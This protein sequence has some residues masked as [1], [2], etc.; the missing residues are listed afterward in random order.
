MDRMTRWFV[1]ACG[2]LL[3]AAPVF[4]ATQNAVVYGTVYDSAGNPMAGVTVTLENPALGFSRASTTGSDGSYNFAEVPPAEGYKLTAAKSGKKLDIRSGITVNVGDERVILPPLK[5]QAA[6]ATAPVVERKSE[7][8]AVR[9]ETVSTT[10]SGVITGDQLRSLPS[11]LNRN[12]LSL[13]T[14][15]PNTHDVEGGS[16]LT[17]ASFSI[18]GTRPATNDF[19]LDGSDNVASSSNQAVPFQVN[20]A[21]QEFRVTSSTASAEYGRNQGGVVNVV[22]RRGGNSFHGSAF[23]YFNNDSL[24]ANN[25]LSVYN[26]TTFDKARAYAGPTAATCASSGIFPLTYNDYVNTACFNGFFT[27]TLAT[28]NTLF[29]PAT[30][31][32]TN[33]KFKQPFSSKQFGINMGG[34]LMKDKWFAFGSYEATLIDNP[35]QIFERVPSNFDRTFDPLGSGYTFTSGLGALDPNYLIAAD[36]MALFPT[37]NV[38]GVPDALEFF[39]GQAP[40]HTTVHNLLLRSDHIHS[41]KTSFTLRYAAQWLNQLHD[42]SLPKQAAYPGNGAIRD[43]FNQ[44]LS[45]S[46]ARTFSPTLINEVRV[47]YSRFNVKEKAQDAGFDATTIG[48]P[49][50]NLPNAAMPTML[51]NGL[52]TQYSGAFPGTNGAFAIWGNGSPM[53]PTLDYFFPMARLGAPLNTPSE[54]RDTTWFAADSVS[55]SRG[56]HAVRFGAEFR[57]LD[58]Q[59]NNGAFSRGFI[60]SSN[61]G[62]F[63]SDSES[64]NQGINDAFR[65]PAFDFSQ[66]QT[67]PY[68]GNFHSYGFAGFIQDTWRFHPRWTLNVGVRYEY[69]S[70]PE[71]ADDRVF[72]F[73]PTANGLVQ[74]G[75]STTIDPFGNGC[76][77]TPPPIQSVPLTSRGPGGFGIVPGTWTCNA[78]GSGKIVKS[79]TNNFAPRVGL[80]WDMFGTGKTVLR[81]GAGWFY[82]HLPVSD[83]SQLL[84]NR[85]TSDVTNPNAFQGRLAFDVIGT[86]CTT[87]LSCGVGSSIINP[88]VQ[89]ATTL[90]GVNPNTFYSAAAQPF[91]MYARDVAHSSTPFTRQMSASV[92]QQITN[93]LAVEVGYIGTSG[94][95]LPVVYNSNYQQEFT[96]FDPTVLGFVPNPTAGSNVL[97][98]VF[99]MTNRGDSTYHSL[100]ARARIAEFHGLR[101]NV[102]YNWSKA[103]DNASTGFFPTVPSTLN[104]FG[105]AYQRGLTA[106]AAILCLLG[107][108][109][110]ACAVNPLVFPGIDFSTGAVTTTG[111]NPVMTSRYL[112]AQ[113]PFNF[114]IDD[115][116]RSD[117]D[118]KNRFVVDYTWDVPSLQKKWGWSKWLDYWQ[119]SG[120]FV[121]QSGQPFTV[122]SGPILGEVNQRA[123][124]LGPVAQNNS[125]PNAA[126]SSTNLGF[127]LVDCI[128]TVAPSPFIISPLQPTVGSACT[129]NSR[130]NQFT[131]P[132]LINFNMAIQKGF[133]VGGENRLLSV[134]AE[135]YNLANRANFYNPIST[136]STDGVNLNPD[137]GRIKS[138]HDPRQIQLAVRYTW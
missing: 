110:G 22:T 108:V 68:V 115:R 89:A 56:K 7:A 59:V 106:N 34:A 84:Y 1:L 23:G 41:D 88:A 82:D 105:I 120:V 52:D 66:T 54:R 79:D 81:F 30:I 21:I 26:G 47:G 16:E 96:L 20:D 10:M 87:N 43:A 55:W 102:T 133:P 24:N 136:L 44:N 128:A 80:A 99:T 51:L 12:F 109:P 129:G 49:G 74:Q 2:L 62:A 46:Y 72:N 67:S 11:T 107:T 25:P 37:A 118:S 17:G 38:I 77:P 9:N 4:A 71:E 97:F 76:T 33:N 29:D 122:F 28:A 6:A 92:Q 45:F 14:L 5:E 127:P 137:F 126:I 78:V 32:A 123:N 58:N 3:L 95:T 100:L 15:T 132:N 65:R 121:G 19:L 104:N 57:H 111:A 130:R 53:R 64:A 131:G 94:K 103:I 8:Q 50:F 39:R 18:S 61:I 135:F 113:D 31:L 40:N 60:Y 36:A 134:R 98:P 75:H 69:F 116:G 42:D 112:I 73:D 48:A 70:P 91:A 125:N 124:I 117:F 27:D 83:V 63:T 90:D 101:M 35:N 93:K 13:G 86:L 85:P 114:L 119:F 138:A